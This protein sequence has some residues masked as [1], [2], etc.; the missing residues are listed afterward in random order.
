M[1]LLID[2]Y[3]SFTYN[4]YQYIGEINPDVQVLR[5]DALTLDEMKGM[6]L[7]CIILSP[8]PGVPED[9]GICVDVV[10][11]FA[12]KVP[13]LGICLGHQAIGYAYGGNVIRA[14]TLKHGKTSMI[15]HNG[16]TQYQGKASPLE[17]FR[18]HSPA[19]EENS[20]PDELEI[21]SRSVDDGVIMA[22]KHKEHA[23]Y[24]LQFHPESIFTKDGQTL[25]RNFLENIAKKTAQP[26]N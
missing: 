24:G 16:K 25:I 5:N 19:V 20:L 7:D 22:M 8:G 17:V 10:R 14:E 12:G 3:D 26:V 18:Y 11:E 9:A 21:L 6:D 4:L 23:V 2:N 13:L 15:T 1:I